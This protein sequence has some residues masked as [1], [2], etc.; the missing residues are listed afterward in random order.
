[1]ETFKIEVQELLSRTVD[2]EAKNIEEAIEKVNQMYNSEEIILDYNDLSKREIIPNDL[3]N[4]KEVLT[5]EVI[6]YLYRDEKKHFE[7]L[8][9]PEN[10][11]FSKL[12]RLRNLV[13]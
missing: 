10:H 2:I 5:K 9:E 12:E 6:E 11:I 4:E 8:E 13:D 1:M 7:E 3:L